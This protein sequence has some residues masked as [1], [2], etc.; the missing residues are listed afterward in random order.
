[1]AACLA[2]R[3]EGM[4]RASNAVFGQRRSRQQALRAEGLRTAG[5]SPQC[6]SRRHAIKKL[7]VAGPRRPAP[8]QGGRW[9]RQAGSEVGYLRAMMRRMV[10]CARVRAT[11]CSAVCQDG[12]E[13][14]AVST[15]AAAVVAAARWAMAAHVCRRGGRRRACG[16]RADCGAGQRRIDGV[17][18]ERDKQQPAEVCTCAQDSPE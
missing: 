5:L 15:A 17:T 7:K 9:R 12:H 2:S 18:A 6:G 11:G 8:Q 14:V 13:R 4:Q 16:R 1:M 3:E 10:A